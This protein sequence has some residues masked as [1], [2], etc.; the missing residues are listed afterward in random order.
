MR[1]CLIAGNMTTRMLD[2]C[3]FDWKPRAKIH[4]RVISDHEANL[5]PDVHA[6]VS[7]SLKNRAPFDAKR[8]ESADPTA[9]R[10]REGPRL[11][12]EA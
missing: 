4:A 9:T 7:P 2:Q 3:K 12:T 10:H 5:A 11:Q 1:F 8:P 6:R